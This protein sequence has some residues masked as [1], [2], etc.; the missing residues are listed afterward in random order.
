[1][2]LFFISN[3]YIKW[4]ALGRHEGSMMLHVP[5]QLV[6]HEVVMMLPG[7]RTHQLIVQPVLNTKMPLQ[8]H[9]GSMFY[10]PVLRFG[11]FCTW[12]DSLFTP[13]TWVSLGFPVNFACLCFPGGSFAILWCHHLRV[14][15]VVLD[16]INV[17]PS[18]ARAER[19]S[20]VHAAGLLPRHVAAA[21]NWLYVRSIPSLLVGLEHFLFFPDWEFHH[22]NWFSYFSEG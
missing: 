3:L 20:P 11:G 19:A 8:D 21:W 15:R 10:V 5:E 22:P 12:S 9:A 14:L 17:S 2:W 13:K 16:L 18:V 4:S 1:M 7:I 6:K